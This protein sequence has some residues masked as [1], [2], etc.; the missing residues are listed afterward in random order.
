MLK[1]LVT[2]SS[3]ALLAASLLSGCSRDPVMQDNRIA[4]P[5]ILMHDQDIQRGDADVEQYHKQTL[6]GSSAPSFQ[7]LQTRL[8]RVFPNPAIT[9]ALGSYV[10]N[11]IDFARLFLGTPYEYGSDRSSPDTFD[12]SDF[13]RYAYLGALGMDLPYDSRSQGDYVDLFS[14]RRYT[15]LSMAERGDLLFFTN[16]KG[17]YEENYRNTDPGEERITHTGIYLGE[18]LMIHTA[19]QATGGVRI[20]YIFGKHLEWRFVKGGGIIQ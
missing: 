8:T 13:T 7:L 11:V 16:Y 10:N 2:Y 1:K 9:P 14:P 15:K 18:G 19:S 6:S 12:C 5:S 4:D 20:D 3:Y 17:P